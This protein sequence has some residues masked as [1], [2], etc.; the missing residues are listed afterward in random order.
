MVIWCWQILLESADW[1][2]LRAGL[3]LS[4]GYYTELWGIAL[5]TK[6]HLLSAQGVRHW[7]CPGD[8]LIIRIQP[9]HTA[10]WAQDVTRPAMCWMPQ[11]DRH[12]ASGE[13]GKSTVCSDLQIRDSEAE[14]GRMHSVG[15]HSRW[16]VCCLHTGGMRTTVRIREQVAWRVPAG[17]FVSG[18]G[19]AGGGR[20][21][22][23]QEILGCTRGRALWPVPAAEGF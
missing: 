2:T 16:S 5:F 13:W 8:T 12:R 1:E 9:L 21:W 18:R 7:P 20:R 17:L 3:R 14:W 6:H 15:E 11:R 22:D 4:E 19:E 23:R 10:A